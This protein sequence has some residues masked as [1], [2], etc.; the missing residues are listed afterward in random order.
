ML[1]PSLAGVHLQESEHSSTVKIRVSHSG[2]ESGHQISGHDYH[3]KYEFS[4]LYMAKT[5]NSSSVWH[6]PDRQLFLN[7]T[8]R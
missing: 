3:D 7:A 2:K 5:T 6:K 4:T 8:H 1:V